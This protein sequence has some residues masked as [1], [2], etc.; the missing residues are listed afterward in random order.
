MIP[1]VQRRGPVLTIRCSCG[2]VFHASKEHVGRAIRCP[3]CS[4][5]VPIVAPGLPDPERSSLPPKPRGTANNSRSRWQVGISL[6]VLVIV[7]VGAY[8]L[9]SRNQPPPPVVV[10]PAPPPSGASLRDPLADIAVV[11][12]AGQPAGS[13]PTTVQRVTARDP[14]DSIWEAAQRPRSV[15]TNPGATAP[16]ARSAQSDKQAEDLRICRATAER[17]PNAKVVESDD[18]VGD[19]PL[20]VN[21][22]TGSDAVVVVYNSQTQAVVRGL[23]V[24]NGQTAS[25]DDIPYG[26]YVLRFARGRDYSGLRQG[27]CVD[28]GAE[29]FDQPVVFHEETRGEKIYA[30]GKTI[31]LHKVV[32]GNATSHRIPTTLIFGR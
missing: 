28:L 9:G 29:E 21:N 31:T 4:A 12:P 1:D 11:R 18:V 3:A 6:L 22:G 30:S 7:A 32:N 27:F 25:V 2:E 26:T 16:K 8:E 20:T 15:H 5:A 23:Y 17:P 19:G 14:L 10:P 13:S 24:R